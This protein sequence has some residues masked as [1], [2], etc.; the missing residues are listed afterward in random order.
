V[1]GV[2][3]ADFTH[4]RAVFALDFPIAPADLLLLSVT[5]SGAG[6]TYPNPVFLTDVSFRYKQS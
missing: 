5:R 1:A 4:F 2:G 3:S 6:D